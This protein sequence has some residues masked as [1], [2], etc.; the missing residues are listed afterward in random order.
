MQEIEKATNQAR[1]LTLHLL[2]FAKG[3]IPTKTIAN[4]KELVL[5]SVNLMLSGSN[6]SFCFNI[7]D[8][9]FLVKIDEGQI[10]QV[11]NNLT[12]NA[13]QAMTKGGTI[14]VNA[15]NIVID[16]EDG[17]SEI[18]LEPGNYI[19]VSFKDEGIGIPAD[20]LSKIFDPYFTSKESGTGLGLATCYSIIKNHRGLIKVE[21][22]VGVGT[23]FYIFLPAIDD[24]AGIIQKQE[25]AI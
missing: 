7:P 5:E 13:M 6:V 14:W 23:K 20:N 22:Q 25:E 1:E 15:E 21:S 9:L 4:F 11:I 16:Q 2:T 3:E 12:I 17:D 18:G 10:K 8:D 19:K 24:N